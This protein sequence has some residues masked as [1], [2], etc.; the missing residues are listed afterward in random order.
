MDCWI[1]LFDGVVPTADGK[2]VSINVYNSE[3]G[4][5]FPIIDD[6]LYHECS[7]L[8]MGSGDDSGIFILENTK[9]TIK[10]D[11][12][13]R[14]YYLYLDMSLPDGNNCWSL[15]V[16]GSAEGVFGANRAASNNVWYYISSFAAGAEIC[17]WWIDGQVHQ[18]ESGYYSFYRWDEPYW[19][20]DQFCFR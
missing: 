1:Q 9:F 4:G 5:Y 3:F 19:L 11:A 20:L 17:S 14:D 15:I 16:E 18:P 13:L 7:D 10:G 6:G 2:P 12:F 8:I